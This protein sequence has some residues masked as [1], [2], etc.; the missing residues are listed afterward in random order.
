MQN[1]FLL[2]I[3]L[4]YIYIQTFALRQQWHGV[5]SALHGTLGYFLFTATIDFGP[6]TYQAGLLPSGSP[7][8]SIVLSTNWIK[9]ICADIIY[10][11]EDCKF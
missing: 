9:M 3:V 6:V 1:N 4:Y 10:V 2:L 8:A 11:L 5:A 7:S